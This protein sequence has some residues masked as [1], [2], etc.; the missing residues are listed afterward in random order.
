VAHARRDPYLIQL[1]PCDLESLA[2]LVE[3]RT[4]RLVGGREMSVRRLNRQVP[5]C[6]DFWQCP[7]DV[8]MTEAKPVHAG[9][10]L[11]VALQNR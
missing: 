7:A 4:L 9:V 3:G 2:L 8:V 1:A 11:Q 6:G 5:A 10:N